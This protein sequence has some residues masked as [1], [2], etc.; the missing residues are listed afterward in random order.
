MKTL[1]KTVLLGWALA[2]AAG[3]LGGVHATSHATSHAEAGS[4][5]TGVVNGDTGWG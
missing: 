3:A 4:G 5:R 2:V 1:R